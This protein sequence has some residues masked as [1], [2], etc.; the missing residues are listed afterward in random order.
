MSNLLASVLFAGVWL[1]YLAQPVSTAW[2]MPNH[3]RGV[4]GVIA[5]ITFGALYIL[6]FNAARIGAFGVTGRQRTE[7]ARRLMLYVPLATAA[8]VTTLLV[9]QDGTATWVFLA[10]AGCWTFRLSIA[11]AIGLA[12]IVA[13][14]L[15]AWLDPGWDRD[16]SLAGA[17]LLAM[18]AVSGAMLASRRQR[19]LVDARRENARLAVQEERNRVARD[20][21]DIL[22]HS[23]TVITV[24]AELAGRLF[25]A[26]PE[27][28]RRE[29]TD[30]ERLSRDALVDVRRAVEGYREI[31]LAGEL[32][33]AR[34]GFAAADIEADV[35]KAI[36]E[37]ES[38][39]RELFAWT[40]REATTNIIRHSAAR[41]AT[42]TVGPTSISI[43]DDGHGPQGDASG[44]GLRGLRERAVQAGAVL[45]TRELSPG[46][47][48]L[49]QTA[50]R[51]VARP[52]DLQRTP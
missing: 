28:A 41:H 39:L 1:V 18:I 26:D 22:G 23:L 43:Q 21:H 3:V 29:V 2:K 50:D 25:D 46:F 30:L 48:L 47:E 27:R 44:N 49:V 20:L 34:E 36:D 7:F 14:E 11:I 33:R 9:G 42:I 31:S 5:T 10:V 16:A 37:V 15:L 4:A 40:V 45:T 35:P 19:A 6:H 32:A 51:P 17:I 38:D 52:T 8:L 12:L 13:Y 24:K